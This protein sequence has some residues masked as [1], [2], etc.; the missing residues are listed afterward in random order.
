MSDLT[1]F[2]NDRIAED[3][4]VAR[5]AMRTR[6]PGRR[7]A[8]FTPDALTEH[9]ERHT[10]E[11]VLVDCEAR[12]RIIECADDAVLELLALRYATHRGYQREWQS[13]TATPSQ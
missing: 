4:A 10:P 13:T 8:V 2:L 6:A 1:D 12:R 7:G 9:H 11:R 5:K 3:E